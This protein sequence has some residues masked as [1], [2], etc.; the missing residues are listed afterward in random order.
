MT[1]AKWTGWAGV[2]G[3]ALGGFF[4]GILLH[5]V[6]QWHHLLSLVDGMDDARTQL[7]WD[8]YFHVLMYVLALAGLW[9]M[10]RHRPRDG[11]WGTPGLALLSG[12]GLWNIVDIGLAHWVLGIHRVRLD[13][14]SP[15]LWDL[16]WLAAFGV[17]PLL[18]ALWKRRRGP[19]A[20]RNATALMLWLTAGAAGAGAWAL[21]PPP[22]ASQ[23]YSTVVFAPGTAPP[24]VVA[25]LDATGARMVWS[26]RAMG[27]VVVAVQPQQRWRFYRHGA[28]LVGGT[29][30][31]AGC[32]SWSRI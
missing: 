4:D 24:Q 1:V 27:V 26:D 2:L 23:A 9:G 30:P 7:L 20:P 14:A 29:L 25:A 15:L 18:L 11:N 8:G 5:Q 17:L 12:F 16:L 22:G 10:W 3:F 21:Q 19:P 13:T 6:L 28:L 31:G 32:V